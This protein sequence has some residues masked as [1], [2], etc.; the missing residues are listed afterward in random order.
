[1][2]ISDALKRNVRC[3]SSKLPPRYRYTH[4]PLVTE[5]HTFPLSIQI[6]T[7]LI[8]FYDAAYIKA[9]D[10]VGTPSKQAAAKVL[11]VFHD[12]VSCLNQF[13][14]Q[15]CLRH[16]STHLSLSLSSFQPNWE[17]RES[18]YALSF[19]LSAWVLW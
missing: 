1:M 11:E 19:S 9:V 2:N 3:N 7:E 10:P 17:H 15:N 5:F 12:T 13:S 14:Q 6:S 8:N 4:T 16:T 18:F